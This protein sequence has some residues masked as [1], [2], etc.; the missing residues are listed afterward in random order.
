METLR[1]PV[2]TLRNGKLQ[3]C[4]PCR[5][6][7]VGCDHAGPICGRCQSR[8]LG[9]S[10]KYLAMTTSTGTNKSVVVRAASSARR[11]TSRRTKTQVLPSPSAP[12]TSQKNGGSVSQDEMAGIS[13]GYLGATSFSAVLQ[14]A[15]NSMVFLNGNGLGSDPQPTGWNDGA[16]PKQTLEQLR[17][18]MSDS[19]TQTALEVI[20]KLPQDLNTS[21]SLYRQH[22]NPN[23]GWVRQA[24]EC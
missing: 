22:V 3:A 16:T 11:K 18:R 23:E 7:K 21:L 4:E 14:E 20:R 17:T 15:K 12:P 9:P 10:C 13:P 24:V 8:N 19:Q 1:T 2:A 5:R 6:R